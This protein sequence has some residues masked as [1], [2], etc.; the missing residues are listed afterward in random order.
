MK[1]GK[2]KEKLSENNLDAF[3]ANQ[4]ARYLAETSAAGAVIISEGQTILITNRMNYDL[5]KEESDIEDV[6]A[7]AKTKI[8]VRERE[9]LLFGTFGE[10]TGEILKEFELFQVGYD[11][12]DEET[13]EDIRKNCKAELSE[14]PDL[15]WELRKKKT[16]E[17]IKKLRKSAEIA[18][19]CMKKAKNIIKQGISEIEVAAEVEY[20]MRKRGSQ[21]TPFDTI[22]AGGKNSLY[23]HAEPAKRKISEQELVTV[24][25]G[26]RWKGYCSDMTRT[27]SVN[28]SDE[29]EEIVKMVKRAQERALEKVEAGVKTSEIDKAARDVLG[30]DFEIFY[31][32][33]TGHGLG[34]DIH[35]PPDLSP[36]SDD[37]LEK[38]MVVTVEPG[39]YVDEVG[40]CR[41]EDTIVVKDDGYE[42]LTSL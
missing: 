25:L 36:S 41:F 31:L 11:Q 18:S 33:G 16:P 27:F 13:Q 32:H 15:V 29:Q 5:A 3:I 6:R 28:P 35:E 7:F 14:N 20:E 37:V 8:P 38:G 39:V 4:N 26:A 42:K 9:N 17:E 2:L 40:G 1:I 19:A 30:E 23:P 10:I 12:L 34:L 24:D 21:G 22:V